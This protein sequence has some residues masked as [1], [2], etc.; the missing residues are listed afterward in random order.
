MAKYGYIS[1]IN[2]PT[3]V[4]NETKSCIDHLFLK[5]DIKT[6]N[7]SFKSFIIETDITDH[8]TI[9]LNLPIES[10]KPCTGNKSIIRTD[11][12]KVFQLLSF[13]N[14][15]NVY[16]YSNSN[17]C[18]NNFVNTLKKHIN[19]ASS[20]SS[21]NFKRKIKPW[22]TNGI[23]QSIKT[24]DRMKK[25]ILNNNNNMQLRDEYKTY[26]NRLTRI[27][28]ITKNNYY[29]DQLNSCN[30]N[31]KQTWKIIRDATNTEKNNCTS[32][33][34][35]LDDHGNVITCNKQKANEFNTFFCNIGKEITNSIPV[36]IDLH[37]VES[38]TPPPLNSLFLRPV[39][40]N[41]VIGFINSLKNDCA[42]GMDQIPAK[43]IKHC[44]TLLTKPLVH[45]INIIF[46]TGCVPDHFKVSI[47][48]PI[49]K[50][51]SRTEKTNYR[52]I[53]VINNLA[54]IFE[55]ALKNRLGEF[56]DKN[57]II[58][59][60]QYGFKS[61]CSTTDAIYR[62]V[63]TINN[64]IQENKKC[65]S[66][67]LDLAKA[68]DTVCHEK[69]LQKL[70]N[71]GIRGTVLK[72][73]ASYLEGRKQFVKIGDAISDVQLITIGVPQGTVLAPILFL[74]FINNLCNLNILGQ[75]IS[76]ADD[77][78]IICTGDDWQDVKNSVAQDMKKI[79]AWLDMNQLSLNVSKTKFIPF[80]IYNSNLPNFNEITIQDSTEKIKHTSTIKYLG[81]M[82]DKNLRWSEHSSHITNKI[83]KLIYK[84]YQL[85]DILSKK[86]ILNIYNSLVE[87]VIRYG[88]IIWGGAY[89]NALNPVKV[90]QKTILKIILKKDP[91]FSSDQ[92]FRECNCLSLKQLYI[93][94]SSIF[95]KKNLSKFSLPTHLHNTRSVENK[96]IMI[97][98]YNRTKQQNFIDY[99]GLSYY[100]NI[101]GY[102]KNI[103]KLQKFRKILKTYIID[104]IPIT[105]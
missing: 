92:L 27:I 35:I 47:V 7:T 48:T 55:K 15:D 49:F 25:Q 56:L 52:P 4:T 86:T 9:Y 58:S 43:L 82:I 80:S 76:Y 103:N 81:L 74:I 46:T 62:L 2:K 59:K 90:I 85:R 14:W 36:P 24:R 97:P 61:S 105:S 5:S 21:K 72:V 79:R 54:K 12:D 32:N 66:V 51:G 3:R 8:Y 67:F 34:N 65:I 99:L 53:S 20:H 60:N 30:G 18:I 77:T 93:L 16:N 63:N 95:I 13:E 44:H 96:N 33:I 68:F 1:L 94:E 64:H 41:D 45:I 50:N 38:V 57:E 75:I 29:T 101:P 104:N 26:R 83:R 102:I 87:S 23:I 91:T 42:T 10:V 78:T 70:E 6:T 98:K 40:E 22:I 11:Y 73:F 28:K 89:E 39:N 100:N 31:I 17:T 69:L 84:F 71:I 19:S 88:L 37:N